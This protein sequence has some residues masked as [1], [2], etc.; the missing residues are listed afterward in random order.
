M[1][2]INTEPYPR[3]AYAWFV[4]AVLL[5]AYILSFIDR[6][7]LSLLVGELKREMNLDDKEIGWLLGAP[8]AL[9]YATCGIFIAW[10]A[11]RGS[12]T[13]NHYDHVH[14]SVN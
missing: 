12:P 3:P 5:L 8:F 1:T 10:L 13:Q 2:T 14:V 6:D 9:F 4:V 11:D 7:V